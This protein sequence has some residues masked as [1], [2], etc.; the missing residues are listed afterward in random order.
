MRARNTQKGNRRFVRTVFRV[1]LVPVRQDIV[2]ANIASTPYLPFVH[3]FHRQ[4]IGWQAF[5]LRCPA[6]P[7]GVGGLTALPLP[8]RRASTCLNL[9]R[10]AV[11]FGTRDHRVSRA[12]NAIA[13]QCYLKPGSP[14][15]RHPTLSPGTSA[16]VAISVVG[17]HFAAA[18]WIITVSERVSSARPASTRDLSRRTCATVS[19]Y[20]RPDC[21]I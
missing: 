6:P 16:T 13:V 20:L 3:L 19:S 5:P 15:V 1:F 21:G 10:A 17:T 12:S 14:S 2:G 7:S 8:H 11:L 18:E 9:V 4:G